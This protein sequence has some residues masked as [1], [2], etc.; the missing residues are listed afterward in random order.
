MLSFFYLVI[1]VK[2]LSIYEILDELKF[3]KIKENK[4]NFLY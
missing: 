4:V 2:L 1:A 3:E